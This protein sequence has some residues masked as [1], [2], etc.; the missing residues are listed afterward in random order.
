MAEDT[1]FRVHK[2]V[3]QEAQ[4]VIIPLEKEKKVTL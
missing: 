4:E 1:Y 2:E 3:M